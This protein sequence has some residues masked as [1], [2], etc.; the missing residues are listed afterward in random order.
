MGS[1]SST[2]DDDE[3]DDDD[4]EEE[5]K[6]EE[7]SKIAPMEKAAQAPQPRARRISVGQPMPP[8]R[9]EIHSIQKLP[10]T[11][12]L[13]NPAVLKIKGGGKFVQY[14]IYQSLNSKGFK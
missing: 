7:D 6:K 11:E 2:I 14:I 12:K 5:E 3:Y 4:D 1:T 10:V 9:G 13:V 8:P